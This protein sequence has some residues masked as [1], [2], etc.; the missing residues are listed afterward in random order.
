MLTL[1]LL[2][3]DTLIRELK[4]QRINLTPLLSEALLQAEISHSRQRRDDGSSYLNQHIYPVA[5][6]VLE[7]CIRERKR[8]S[9]EL[10]AG[11]LLHDVLEDDASISEGDFLKKFGRD[12]FRIVK[13][14]TKTTWKAYPGKSDWDKRKLAAETYL[15]LLKK[16]PWES[17]IIKLADR[18]N[19]I[20]SVHTIPDLNKRTDY[21]RETR[22]FYLPF[23]EKVSAFF[24]HRLQEKLLEQELSLRNRR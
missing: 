16:A 2:T 7:Y 1:P 24:Y 18:L 6:L 20:S 21:I 9:E 12:I 15:K 22:E 23:S 5:G 13:P 10:L 17:K 19:N 14:L 3:R 8:F 4:K 11:A